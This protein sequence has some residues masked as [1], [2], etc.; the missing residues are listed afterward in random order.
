MD[1][2]KQVYFAAVPVITTTMQY[3]DDIRKWAITKGMQAQFH[4]NV[5]TSFTVFCC[6]HT[7]WGEELLEYTLYQVCC[8]HKMELEMIAQIAH[9]KSLERTSQ[10]G[11]NGSV[12]S[13]KLQSIK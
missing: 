7:Y 8:D 12:E 1:K 4:L 2:C 10:C 5:S 11:P 3:L 6:R 13:T 9:Y